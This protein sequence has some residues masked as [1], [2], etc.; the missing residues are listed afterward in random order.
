MLEAAHGCEHTSKCTWSDPSLSRKGQYAPVPKFVRIAWAASTMPSMSTMANH[1]RCLDSHAWAVR[2][3]T[4]S[5]RY[6]NHAS[7][8][9]A[10][11]GAGCAWSSTAHTRVHC[12]LCHRTDCCSASAGPRLRSTSACASWDSGEPGSRLEQHACGR[13]RA[14]VGST[15]SGDASSSSVLGLWATAAP[16]WSG[17]GSSGAEDTSSLERAAS[18]SWYTAR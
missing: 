14:A 15:V 11:L 4:S 18:C 8:R 13:E 12:S 6:T 1:P 16:D 3:L 7:Q 5:S 10:A 2:A 17:C 9:L